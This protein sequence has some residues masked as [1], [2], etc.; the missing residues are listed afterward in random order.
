MGNV[1]RAMA[2][3]VKRVCLKNKNV[4]EMLIAVCGVFGAKCLAENL[5]C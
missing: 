1:C 5:G 3:P 4:F 2:F